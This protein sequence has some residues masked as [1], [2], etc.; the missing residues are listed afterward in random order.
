MSAEDVPEFEL[1]NAG[2]GPDRLALDD[3]AGDPDA[4]AVVLLFHRDHY[5][6]NCRKQVQAVADRY[7]EF[8]AA[9][10]E[11]AS[12]LPEPVERAESWQERY[13]LPF[14][15]LADPSKDV[16]DAYDQPTRFGRLGDLHDL[17]GRMPETVV[18]DVR[19][20]DPEV[21][22]VHRGSSPADR[23]DVNELLAMLR[24]LDGGGRG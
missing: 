7:D 14:P 20:G 22:H 9:G 1:P 24:D 16:A 17:L 2:A 13:D 8:E 6:G 4:D 3:L 19:D 18:L 5:C 10:A 12:V 21:A 15:L 11:V 23:P